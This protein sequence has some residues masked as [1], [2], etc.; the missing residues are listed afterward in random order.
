[1]DTLGI[2][3]SKSDF[4][5]ALF[6]GEHLAK[7]SFPNS[8]KG[9][10]QLDGWLRN[11]NVSELQACMESTGPYWT[12]L[13]MHLFEA[14]HKVAVVNPRRIKKF[15]ESLL[16]RTKT[17]SADATII[18]R[19]ALTQQPRL[20][21]PLPPEILELQ[22]LSRHLD[23]LKKSR[24]QHLV[25]AQTPGLPASVLKSAQKIIAELDAQIAELQKMVEDHID[26]HPGLKAD[27]KLLR[28]IP[29]IGP[30]TSSRILSEIPHLAE[31]KSKQA[32]SAFVGLSPRLF[33]SGSSIRGRT[34]LC[35][36]G[37]ARSR[38]A[39]YMAAVVA[40]NHNPTLKAFAQRLLDAGKTKMVV[41]GAVMRKLIVL[42]YG[43]LKSGRPYDPNFRAQTA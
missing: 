32:V 3:I 10:A 11:R 25:R 14:G 16:S 13:A 9:F 4:H 8:S 19:F 23:F 12:N 6:Q 31:F 18:G 22:G 27:K 38:G 34:H 33:E 35:K 28:S 15:A 17:D 21:K 20:W 5:A 30:A 39:L 24:V 42:A 1:M 26:R 29:G 2:D 43:V 40:K 37:S 7:K 41:I 36:T